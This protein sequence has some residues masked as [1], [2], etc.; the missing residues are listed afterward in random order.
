VLDCVVDL[1]YNIIVYIAE[2]NQIANKRNAYTYMLYE[3]SQVRSVNISWGNPTPK[4]V[5]IATTCAAM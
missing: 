1:Y 4:N 5:L 3:S 2:I